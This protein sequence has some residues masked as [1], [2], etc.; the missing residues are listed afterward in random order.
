MA[1]IY[2][3]RPVMRGSSDST[4]PPGGDGGIASTQH[5]Y[6]NYTGNEPD[7]NHPFEGESYDEF[8]ASCVGKLTSPPTGPS[9]ASHAF[10]LYEYAEGMSLYAFYH[11]GSGKVKLGCQ[12][13]S[14]ITAGTIFADSLAIPTGQARDWWWWGMSYKKAG[15][16]KKF[17]M[18]NLDT[19][20][21]A[22]STA[23]PGVGS[24]ESVEWIIPSTGTSDSSCNWGF[25]DWNVGGLGSMQNVYQGYLSQIYLHNKYI[26]FTQAASRRLF[27]AT[28]GII[29]YGPQ[30]ETPF[31]ER[32]LVYLPY[33]HPIL[34]LGSKFI[35][36][37]DTD[38]WIQPSRVA[39]LI[40]P[41]GTP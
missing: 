22:S 19:G 38:F 28:D 30:G 24:N 10:N 18:V 40:P 41:L 8:T 25:D 32:P 34:N 33:G 14:Q 4:P 37:W 13:G 36:N 9:T 21:E 16:I 11:A 5:N 17:A 35:G 31:A 3:Y 15:N 29:S 6:R 7:F 23:L 26:D 12:F 1:A 20:Y 2:G 39:G 27:C